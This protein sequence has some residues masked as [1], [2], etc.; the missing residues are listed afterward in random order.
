MKSSL[1]TK[2][3]RKMDELDIRT[4]R[5]SDREA[6][7]EVTLAAYQQYAAVMLSHWQDYRQ[8]ILTTLAEVEP[9][10]QIVAELEG[11]IVGTV[12]IYPAGTTFSDPEGISTRLEWPEVRLLAVAPE[13]RSRG[14]GTALMQ[15]CIRRARESGASALTLHTSDMMQVAMHMYEHM[16]FERAPNLDFRPAQDVLVKGYRLN[17]NDTA[18]SSA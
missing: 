9:D 16:G 8:N 11:T 15:A 2:Q 1:M 3:D 10:R 5:P 14:V 18:P 7:R 4:A 6:I 17:L 13:A 12:L